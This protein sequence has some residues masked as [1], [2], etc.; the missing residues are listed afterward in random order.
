VLNTSFVIDHDLI[1][2]NEL[3]DETATTTVTLAEPAAG[4][5][6]TEAVA[7]PHIACPLRPNTQTYRSDYVSISFVIY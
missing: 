2:A 5:H 6:A 7:T 1:D 4:Q 3:P